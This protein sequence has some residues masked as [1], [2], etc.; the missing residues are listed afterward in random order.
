[1]TPIDALLFNEICADPG[2]YRGHKNQIPS[3]EFKS[4]PSNVLQH[5]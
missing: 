3:P 5:F 4:G 2:L 1:M